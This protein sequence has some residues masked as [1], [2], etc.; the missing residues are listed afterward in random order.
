MGETVEISSSPV[1]IIGSPRSGTTILARSL[2]E[3]SAFWASDES[4]FLS[5]LVELAPDIYASAL[6]GHRQSWIWAQGVGQAEF[7]SCLGTGVNA[8]FTSR[9]SGR[10]WVEHTPYYLEVAGSLAEM[11]PEARFIHMLRDGRRVVHSMLHLL[12]RPRVVV[13]RARSRG[14]RAGRWGQDFGSACRLWVASVEAARAFVAEHPERARTV[15][16]ERLAADPDAGFRELFDFLGVDAEGGPAE[17]F[18]GRRLNSSFGE[19]G[20]L[21]QAPDPEPWLRWSPEQRALFAAEAG[22]TLVA[23]G[24]AREDELAAWHNRAHER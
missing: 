5:R 3:H 9:S 20:E 21:E 4:H 2:A 24:F 1:F 15:V 18:R 14:P 8:L 16:H 23:C 13:G 11:F 7:L 19:D 12:D 22:G 6:E 17:L 10:R